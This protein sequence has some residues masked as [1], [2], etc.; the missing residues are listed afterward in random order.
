[1][2]EVSKHF[3]YIVTLFELP[4]QAL[5]MLVSGVNPRWYNNGSA[6]EREPLDLE[7]NSC[8]VRLPT[9]QHSYVF[10]THSE[11]QIRCNISRIGVEQLV[12]ERW[13]R[14]YLLQ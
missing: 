12:V 5:K 8:I 13:L 6:G 10:Q 9:L 3:F 2:Y 1:M 7:S 4:K 14:S 11:T